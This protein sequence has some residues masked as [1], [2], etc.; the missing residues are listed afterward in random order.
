LNIEDSIFNC[1]LSNLPKQFNKL[2]DLFGK[3]RSFRSGDPL[4]PQTALINT[5]QPEQ[6]PCFFDDLLTSYITF[7]VMTVAD[8][9]AGNQDA[10]RSVQKSLEQKAVVHPAGTHEPDQT[11]IGRIL[12]AGHS[13]QISAGIRAPVADKG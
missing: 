9:S 6:F 3:C 2:P 13:G 11:Y 7:Q 12:H 5:K 4:Q 1:H 8:V 10:V